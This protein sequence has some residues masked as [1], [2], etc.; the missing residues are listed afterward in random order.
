MYMAGAQTCQ[1]CWVRRWR[2]KPR[3]HTRQHAHSFTA[4]YMPRRLF[5]RK[6]HHIAAASHCVSAQGQ[7]SCQRHSHL[8]AYKQ[9]G[10]QD[11]QE[12]RLSSA[13]GSRQVR[14]LSSEPNGSLFR[15]YSLYLKPS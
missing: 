3:N 5:T 1:D 4:L 14:S 13:R 7:Q 15:L 9:T 11:T 12:E 6:P 10:H 2:R 8:C